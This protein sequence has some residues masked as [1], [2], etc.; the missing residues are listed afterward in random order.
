MHFLHSEPRLIVMNVKKYEWV[1][2]IPFVTT[3][4]KLLNL[5]IWSIAITNNITFLHN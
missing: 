4:L 3:N 2:Y 5:L 1:L